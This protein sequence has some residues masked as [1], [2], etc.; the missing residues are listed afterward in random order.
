MFDKIM[1]LESATKKPLA[2]ISRELEINMEE[3]HCKFPPSDID[4]LKLILSRCLWAET[5]LDD[6]YRKER[7]CCRLDF[8]F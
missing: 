8:G 6:G 2:L 3:V 5:G 4:E 7:Y 1:I